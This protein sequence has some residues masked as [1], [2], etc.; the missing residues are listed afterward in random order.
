MGKKKKA[1]NGNFENV[2]TREKPKGRI[3][4]IIL[5]TI[6]LI[7]L[8]VL[9]AGFIT[10]G[11]SGKKLQEQLDLGTKYLDDMDYE[12]A[13]VAFE[14]VLEI[15]P[16]NVDA[17]LGIVEVY[18]R[19]NEFEKALECAKEGYEVTGDKRLK[20]KIKMIESGDIFASNGWAMKMTGYDGDG[21][22]VYWHEYTYNLKGQQASVAKYNA[23]GVQEQYLELTYDE[24]GRT[25]TYYYYSNDYGDIVKHVREYSDNHYRETVYEGTSDVV[26][27]YLE[28]DTDSDGKEL[29]EE[30]YDL[31]GNIWTTTI[32]EYDTAGNLAKRS[33]YNELGE[34]DQY[35]VHIYDEDGNQLLQQLYRP[36]GELERYWENIY[37]EDGNCIG[38]R[39]YDAEGNLQYET[40][41]Q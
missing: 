11:N 16:M 31:D 33:C 27:G 13:L 15:D 32:Y 23:Q 25:L 39:G 4:L 17:Y 36:D 3:P 26:T 8:A 2:V 6:E 38:D 18:I 28:V 40:V 20:E 21:N 14:A 24:E 41:N 12:Q 7:V 22:L 37:D 9:M 29:K 35:Y 10:L 34:L 30:V 1:E 5:L 19:T